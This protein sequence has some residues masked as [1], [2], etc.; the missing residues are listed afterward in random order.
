[1]CKTN[2]HM[3]WTPVRCRSDTYKSRSAAAH[4][5]A[6]YASKYKDEDKAEGAVDATIEGVPTPVQQNESLMQQIH[7]LER[8]N[9]QLQLSIL[10]SQQYARRLI[11]K[12]ATRD[13]RFHAF[14]LSHL[15]HMA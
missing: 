11:A 2:V 15:D 7:K 4:G 9:C 8:N 10:R 12:I 5:V 3:I 13:P 1:M 6:L 14:C